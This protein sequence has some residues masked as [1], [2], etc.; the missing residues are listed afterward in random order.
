MSPPME[1]F[2][3]EPVLPD[4]G[5]NLE[6][7]VGRCA[8]RYSNLA[9]VIQRLQI[10]LWIYQAIMIPVVLYILAKVEKL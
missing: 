5:K 10:T 6:T 7:H 2:G 8:S 1:I 4:E 3:K 9:R